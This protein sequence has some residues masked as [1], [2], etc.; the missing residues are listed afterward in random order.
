MR[1]TYLQRLYQLAKED[2][3]V[4]SLVA[5]NGIIVYDSFRDDF[6]ERFYNF[7]ISESHMVS[8]AAGMASS[9]LIPYVYTISAFLAYRAYEF[10]RDDICY[11]NQNV[12]I[13]GIG[14]GLTYSTLGP[15]HHTTEDIGLLRSLPNLTVF[16]PCCKQ[17]AA[18]VMQQSYE[19]NG[20]VYIRLG[21][22]SED[23]YNEGAQ[24]VCGVPSELRRGKGAAVFVT[25]S[26]AA[27]AKRAADR[28]AADGVEAAV[29]SV[30][31]LKP[32]QE[33]AIAQMIGQYEKII[34]VDEHNRI[35][36][37]C[38]ALSEV[39]VAQ[40]VLRPTLNIGLEDQFAVGYGSIDEVRRM[41][42]IDEDA[43]YEKIKTF[44]FGRD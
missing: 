41:N 27:V 11:Q 9:G 25:G 18:W 44:L 7:G 39:M 38:S 34:V 20:P 8:A 15:S 36:G 43:I 29:Y 24:F 37:L 30:H 5:D 12:K 28:L 31:T 4:V 13:V 16:S 42:G 2:E 35:G 14:S 19:I 22:N 32:L 3:R 1:N 10:L 17:E 26:I 6:P 33:A 21:N 40:Q 23:Y